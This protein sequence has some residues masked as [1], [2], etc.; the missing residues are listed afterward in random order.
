MKNS[1][2]SKC[3]PKEWNDLGGE[4]HVYF[5]IGLS[6]YLPSMNGPYNIRACGWQQGF[7]YQQSTAGFGPAAAFKGFIPGPTYSCD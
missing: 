6:T 5:N 2:C 3:F 7:H 1:R 4:L